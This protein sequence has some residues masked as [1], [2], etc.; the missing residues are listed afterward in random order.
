MSY[1]IVYF[2]FVS[3]DYGGVEQ[4]IISQ[5]DALYKLRANAYLFLV[6][7]FPPG[8]KLSNEINKRSNLNILINSVEK[9]KNP[10]KRRKEKFE[11][12]E[13]ALK[14]FVPDSTFVYLRYPGADIL[15][16]N[17]LRNNTKYIF[18]TEHQEIENTFPLF[19]FNGNYRRNIFEIIWGRTV[20]KRITGIVGVTEEILSYEK[21]R[22]ITD[23]KYFAVIGNGI[24]VN[25]IPLRNINY[26]INKLN[27]IRI[28]FVGAGFRTHGLAR[29]ILSISEYN[30]SN[31]HKIKIKLIVAGESSEMEKNIRLASKLNLSESIDFLGQIGK[32]GLNELYNWA[33]IGVGSLGLHRIGLT[34]SSTLKAREYC[35]IGLPFFW[36]TKDSDFNKDFPY[37]VEIPANENAFDL[38][39]IIKFVNAYFSD[40]EHP[41]KMRQYASEYLD[42]SVKMKSLVEFFDRIMCDLHQ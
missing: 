36:S 1:S 12:I 38:Q 14:A 8:E 32:D 40:I 16:L 30:K 20:R 3:A 23:K 35:A 15:F 17:F 26:Q 11:L 18:I 13:K 31:K 29:L 41:Q 6:S 21:S 24:N 37:I 27:E 10:W 34:M 7:S 39:I 25:A 33:H 19:K 42:W 5:F 9:I 2:A 22:T 28:L 4:K